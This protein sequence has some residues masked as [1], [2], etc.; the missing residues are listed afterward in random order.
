[1]PGRLR[2]SHAHF[3]CD[4]SSRDVQLSWVDPVPAVQR[5][6]LRS[7]PGPHDHVVFRS[8]PC[9]VCVSCGIYQQDHHFLSSWKVQ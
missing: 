3:V 8:L 7:G 1:M 5:W 6:P 9:R 2:V 4:L